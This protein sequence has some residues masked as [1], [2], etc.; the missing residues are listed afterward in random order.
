MFVKKVME[1]K[2]WGGKYKRME[3]KKEVGKKGKFTNKMKH[4]IK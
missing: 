3:R 4:K 2:K 1:R